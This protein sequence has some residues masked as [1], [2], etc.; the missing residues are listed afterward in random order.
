[1]KLSEYYQVIK[2]NYKYLK[3]IPHTSAKNNKSDEIAAYV[4]QMYKSLKKRVYKEN[5]KLIIESQCKLSYYIYITK[6]DVSFY[7][8]V[9]EYYVN[10]IKSK[11]NTVWSNKVNIEEVEE[12]PIFEDSC[13]KC[14][15]A[16]KNKDGLSLATDK[17]NNDLLSS[18]LSVINTMQE[19]DAV[20][21]IYNMIPLSNRQQKTWFTRYE[22]DY[23]AY[24]ENRNIQK[25]NIDPQQLIKLAFIFILKGLNSF[26]N[27]IQI[28]LANEKIEVEA[29]NQVNSIITNKKTLSNATIK[30]K[31]DTII[32]T[33]IA[34]LSQ[35]NDEFQQ[36]KLLDITSNSFEIIKED[37]ELI[38]KNTKSKF[39]ILDYDYKIDTLECSSRELNNG[40]SIPGDG[41]L[42]EYKK[43]KRN[44]LN[45]SILPNEL[46]IGYISLGRNKYKNSNEKAYFNS[47]PSLVNLPIALLGG[48]RSGKST[49]AENISKNIIDAG[50]GLII[51]DFIKNCEFAD[52]IRKIT[53]IDRL[54]VL[55]LSNPKYYQAFAY[56]EIEINNSMSTLEKIKCSNRQIV[57][58]LHLIDS[59]NSEGIQLTGKMSRY[60]LSAGK[61][62][63]LQAGT[64]LKDVIRCLQNFKYRNE[65]I[66][67]LNDEYGKYLEEDIDNLLELN[68]YDKKDSEKV[69]GTKDSKIEGILDRINL[70]KRDPNMNLM[71]SLGPETNINFLDAMNQGKV[72]LIKLPEDEFS[73]TVSKNVMVTFF[74]TKIWLVTLMR[75]KI[76][77]PIR[78]TVLID[79]IFQTPMAQRLVGKQLVQSAKFNLRYIFTLHYLNQLSPDVKE[80][81]KNANSSYC[82][83]AGCDKKAF[84]ELEEEFN[85][86]GYELNDLLKLKEYHS[87]NLIKTSNS[88][89]SFITKLPPPIN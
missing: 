13:S 82:L 64:G 75:S 21:I 8:I 76:N 32:K 39:S 41:L 33:Q 25:V 36:N 56:N 89:S 12:I 70:L 63:F 28:A 79:E 30:K 62:V 67:N 44:E 60:L 78:C 55:D 53:P 50:E 19:G 34:I 40:V 74:I 29:L 16:Y 27:E 85:V 73:D 47:K 18:N 24:K 83:I 35:S 49:F 11:I 77:N 9:P 5:N 2:P 52:N 71:Y 72:V 38:P 42:E 45:E 31:N 88:Y 26:I 20:G 17:R 7:F 66:E 69:I 22:E 48:S 65:L 6:D 59:I 14:C 58:I 84:K 1:M 15:M 51:L 87:L 61:L 54:I 23:K 37:N 57:Q 4:N 68:E 80:A 86:N 10:I 3:I 43:I 81:L 46:K